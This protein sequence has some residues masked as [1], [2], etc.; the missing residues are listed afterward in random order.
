MHPLLA[1]HIALL[2]GAGLIMTAEGAWLIAPTATTWLQAM[3]DEQLG[4]FLLLL[5]NPGLWE[6][7]VAALGLH[8]T[9]S[10]DYATYIRQTL[11]RQREASSALP[12]ATS[13]PGVVT[14][15][16]SAE[17]AYWLEETAETA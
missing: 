5:E 17:P 11:T 6:Q 14:P 4:P 7:T 16:V 2:Q 8:T 10:C 3:P 13:T 9:L 1:I 12:V 15:G